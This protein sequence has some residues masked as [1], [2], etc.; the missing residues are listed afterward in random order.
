MKEHAEKIKVENE[1]QREAYNREVSQL[2]VVH[3]QKIA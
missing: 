1:K 3:E 2:Q